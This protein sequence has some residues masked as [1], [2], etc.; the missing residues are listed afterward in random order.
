MSFP[1]DR[2]SHDVAH[3]IIYH[4]HRIGAIMSLSSALGHIYL[5]KKVLHTWEFW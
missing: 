1:E 3:F 2:F 5:A 4:C